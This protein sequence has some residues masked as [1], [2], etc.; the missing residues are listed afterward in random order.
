MTVGIVPVVLFGCVHSAKELTLDEAFLDAKINLSEKPAVVSQSQGFQTQTPKRYAEIL[1]L[2]RIDERFDGVYGKKNNSWYFLG[3]KNIVE[4]N[5]R[6]YWNIVR[7]LSE[8][9]GCFS[10][11]KKDDGNKLKFRC[12]DGK[13]IIVRRQLDDKHAFFIAKKL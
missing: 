5:D 13:K 7:V 8:K 11:Q 6:M 4:N 9:F 1:K 3:D 2:E 10:N 12:R